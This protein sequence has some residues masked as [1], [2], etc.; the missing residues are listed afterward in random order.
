MTKRSLPNRAEVLIVGAGPAGSTLA[1]LLGRLGID[2]VLADKAE[3]PRGKT[4]AGG[5]NVRTLNLLPFDLSPVVEEVIT[6]ISFTCNFEK[7]F[8]R[9]YPQPLMVTVN[10]ENFDHFLAK[11]AEQAGA[12]FSEKTSISSFH[13]RDG[14]VEVQTSAGEIR[15]NYVVG[16][17]GAQST[18]AKKLGFMEGDFNILAIHSEAPTSLIPFWEPE[19]IHIDWGSI[20]R[21]YA[22]LFPKKNFLSVG[23][24][25]FKIPA[26]KIKNYHRAFL[27]TRCQ[28]D[29]AFPFSAAGFIIPLRK[30]RG[31]IQEGRCLLLGDAAG[32]ADPFT[33]E[34]IYSAIRSAQIAAPVLQ[35]ALKADWDSLEPFQEAIDRDLM[36]ELEC[37]RLFREIFNLR[38]AFFHE[39]IRSN[40]RWWRA[41]AK[42]MRGEKSFLDVK[43]KLGPTGSLLMRLAR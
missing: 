41:M 34:G 16:A 13:P 20:R 9:R 5:I 29:R 33:G 18:V 4:C 32:L 23:A 43:K 7:P 39:K 19:V 40:D 36:P 12:K 21:S 42:I 22:Y 35:E 24:G 38:P 6:G 31:N 26:P 1:Y 3:F 14:F 30:K 15:A 37:S 17:D 8:Q 11:Q 28:K 2:V 27:E 25:G 10:R